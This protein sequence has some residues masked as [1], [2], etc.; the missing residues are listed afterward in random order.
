MRILVV[1]QH[2]WPSIGGAEVQL[3]RLADCWNRAGQQV[4]V[5]TCRWRPEQPLRE[6]MDGVQ[7]VRLP[8]WRVRFLGTIAYLWQID[9][10]IHRS[11]AEF[12]LLYVSMLKHAAYACV[13]AGRREGLPVVLRAEGAGATGDIAWQ[14]SA[15]LGSR[16]RRRCQLADAFVAP[17]RAVQDEMQSAGYDVDRLH[18]LPNGVPIP[19][20]PWEQSELS[21]HRCRLGI[22]DC[23]TIG[24]TGRLDAQKGLADLLQAVPLLTDAIGPVQVLLV[25]EGP[26]RHDLEQLVDRLGIAEQVRF[27]GAVADV[28]PYLRA[29]DVYALPSY[30]EG[31][32]VSLLEALALGVPAIASDIDANRG[33]LPTE[34]LPLVPVRDSAALASVLEALLRQRPTSRS[35]EEIRNSIAK[36]F[37]LPVIAQRHL[38]LFEQ[39]LGRRNDFA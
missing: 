1:T 29:C 15:R 14:A 36:R 23:P 9:H 5:L 12:D 2:F 17:G 39:L 35:R 33:I 31:L 28:E 4:T 7:V 8:V 37:G 6:R 25:G 20:H 10:W 3:R 13:K 16:V 11:R 34:Q 22:P 26:A 19:Q 21:S 27:V 32:S 24:Y 38:D 30:Y 18:L